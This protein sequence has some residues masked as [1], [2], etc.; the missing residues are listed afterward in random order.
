MRVVSWNVNGIR[1]CV[2]HGFVD[3]VDRFDTVWQRYRFDR[4]LRIAVMDAIERVEVA[5]RAALIHE[6]AMRG[7]PSAHIDIK[8]FPYA[9]PEQHARFLEALRPRDAYPNRPQ[10]GS[11]RSHTSIGSASAD[12]A[13]GGLSCRNQ[14]ASAL[15]R[16]AI[17]SIEP[18]HAA[19]QP[20][21]GRPVNNIKLSG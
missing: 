3:F 7:G 21:A 16:S 9:K 2:R 4:Q 10:P 15:P 11:E 19:S 13:P 1:A 12:D 5:I 14:R 17:S 18:Y 8:N 6:L 20:S